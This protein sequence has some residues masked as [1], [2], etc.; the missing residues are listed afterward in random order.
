[1][2]RKQR[3]RSLGNPAA[4]ELVGQLF[5]LKRRGDRPHFRRLVK[6]LSAPA[7]FLALS[8]RGGERRA[9]GPRRSTCGC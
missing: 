2:V 4:A 6:I 3:D 5:P 9:F 8:R 1:M 7:A